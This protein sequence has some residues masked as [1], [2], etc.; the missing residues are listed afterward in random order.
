[1]R[2]PSLA[3][4]LS[5][6]LV[7]AACATAPARAQMSHDMGTSLSKDDI[8]ALAKLEVAIGAAR[9]SAQAQLAMARN[10]TLSAQQELRDKLRTRVDELIRRSGMSQA[11]Y[12][13]R[14]YI[15]STDSTARRTFDV[16]VAQLTGV[17]TP[18]QVLAVASAPAVKVPPGA[19][20]THL[21]HV[22]NSFGDTPNEQGL[23]PTALAEAKTAAQHAALGVRDPANLAAMKLHAGHVIN[24]LDPTIVAA[25]PGLGYGLKRA[26]LNIAT[27]IDLA[28]KSPGASPNVVAHANHVSTAARNVAARAE[29]AIAVAQKVQAAT[30]PAEAAGLMNQLV[31]LT[32]QLTSG[33]DANGDGKVTWQDPEGGLQQAEEHINLLLAG[34]GIKP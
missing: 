10:K 26:A 18:G 16:V 1:V 33:F 8:T 27:H 23:L 3:R 2:Y 22:L 5:V 12:N 11:D 17:P 7:L 19:V 14:T 25:G 29:Q 31:S 32:A 6:F 24:A 9:D 4:S 34:E 30:T 15:V 13:R 21:G 28:A 20:G